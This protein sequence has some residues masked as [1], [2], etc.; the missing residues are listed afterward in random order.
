M[1]RISLLGSRGRRLAGSIVVSEG[2]NYSGGVYCEASLP[3]LHQQ[4][5]YPPP[6]M[7]PVPPVDVLGKVS[8]A[9]TTFGK[10]PSLR[11]VDC[12]LSPSSRGSIPTL[13]SHA[14]KSLSPSLSHTL[15][16]IAIFWHQAVVSPNPKVSQWLQITRKKLLG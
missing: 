3:V 2:R 11:T 12:G 16:L 14:L 8:V 5:Y 4:T 15:V 9:D 7:A 13:I 10:L 6:K 1:C